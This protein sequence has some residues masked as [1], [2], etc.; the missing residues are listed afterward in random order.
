[1]V[2]A[3]N[4][5]RKPLTDNLMYLSWMLGDEDAFYTAFT[6]EDGDA[7]ISRAMAAQRLAILEKTLAML[8]IVNV[9]TASFVH[10]TLFKRNNPSGL[11]GLFQHAAIC[12]HP[13][14]PAAATPSQEAA[15]DSYCGG[16]NR[17]QRSCWKRAKQ[18]YF[19]DGTQS[20]R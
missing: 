3:N 7:V 10:E 20:V 19:G 15:L 2:V 17:S 5:L 14:H 13:G 9:L 12:A 11:Y 18:G 4:L 6:A 8:P 1:M 16:P